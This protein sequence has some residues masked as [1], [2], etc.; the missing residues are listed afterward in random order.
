MAES[1]QIDKVEN[2]KTGST[3]AADTALHQE[4]YLMKPHVK[5]EGDRAQLLNTKSTPADQDKTLVGPTDANKELT[6]TIM[7]KSKA[8]DQEINKTLEKVVKHQIKPLTDKEFA[9]KFGADPDAVQRVLKLAA[10]N[11]LKAADVDMRSG[12]IELKG[13]AK[14]FGGAFKVKLN[15]YQDA[16]GLS[17]QQHEGTLS[18]PKSMR[19]DVE[20]IFGL[21]SKPLAT[22]KFVILPP[23]GG[24]EP[25]GLFTGY[26]PGQVAEAYN[27]PKESMGA[28]QAVAIVE[29]GGGL[30]RADN[31]A[32]YKSH[33]LK[34]PEINIVTVGGA[35]NKVGGAADG[36]VALDSQII[37]AVA[38][39][40]KQML[41]FG[42]N[43]DQGFLDTITRATFTKPGEAENSAISV[44]WGA[45]ES[46]WAPD[47][48]RAMDLAFKKAALKGISIF[49]ASGDTGA[50]DNAPDKKYTPDFP[51]ADPWVT[52][53]GGTKLKVDASGHRKSEDAWNDGWLI[54]LGKT[55]A[56][57]GG[58]SAFF[59]V[60]DYQAGVKMPPNANKTGVPG[61]GVP[62]IAGNASV[63]EGYQVRFGG[64]EMPI[65]GTSAVAPLYAALT[66]RLN[67][68][69]GHPVGFLN[70][71]LYE[72]GKNGGKIFHDIT[73]G[74]NAGYNAGPGWDAT[75]GWGTIDGQKMLDALRKSGK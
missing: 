12:R 23:G 6:V 64:K 73:N 60:P 54:G 28:G 53:T 39:D 75:T 62:D 49:C 38:P 52:G 43:T 66:M 29:L 41:I 51:S 16:T 71:F 67:G 40:A 61:R 4:A 32:Y 50:K 24:I 46:S 36:E 10:D 37:G 42:P 58:I 17:F 5:V 70:P 48:M 44:S 68:A 19:K 57:G 7:V 30:D 63:L 72:Q 34:E 56:G 14:D 18:V 11:N 21:D 9:D 33:N 55:V 22:P 65:G 35:E 27:F 26:M 45:P 15:E 31:S 20:G 47:A 69:L 13:A 1:G 25:H 8:S 3:T 74:D 59:Q 2:N